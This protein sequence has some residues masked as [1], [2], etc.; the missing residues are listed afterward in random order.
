MI[1]L[2]SI[3]FR[4]FFD[5]FFATLDL[6]SSPRRIINVSWARSSLRL[7]QF[8]VWSSIG[9]LGLGALFDRL[10][11]T[12]SNQPIHTFILDEKYDILGTGQ[13]STFNVQRQHAFY[14]SAWFLHTI[15][16][17]SATR[18]DWISTP[19]MSLT[20]VEHRKYFK[21]NQL[22]RSPN[23]RRLSF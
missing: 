22:T 5:S 11:S 6:R 20:R 7:T 19:K 9:A 2:S 13:T 17:Y 1:E 10:R 21:Q 14:P 3:S 18:S 8:D 15:L 23:G 16:F 4:R 12:K